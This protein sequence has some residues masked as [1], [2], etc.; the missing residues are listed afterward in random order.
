MY[1]NQSPKFVRIPSNF[2]VHANGNKRRACIDG[3][4]EVAR[5]VWLGGAGG[6][7]GFHHM[8]GSPGFP[9]SSPY[10]FIVYILRALGFQ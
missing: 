3:R 8:F 5:L 2:V 4:V 10:I 9:I 6:G 7:W 1:A